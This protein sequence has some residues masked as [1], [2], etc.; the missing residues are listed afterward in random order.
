M[1]RSPVGHPK[2]LENTRKL[3]KAKRDLAK[4]P[5]PRKTIDKLYENILKPVRKKKSP[6]KLAKLMIHT[7]K[8]K[9]KKKKKNMTKAK[10]RRPAAA[11][12]QLRAEREDEEEHQ[13]ASF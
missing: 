8:K 1:G 13:R 4:S 3:I 5:K 6:A 12:L 2:S 10:K 7:R 11:E 9:K